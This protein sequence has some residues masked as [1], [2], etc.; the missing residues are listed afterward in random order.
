MSRIIDLTDTSEDTEILTSTSTSGGLLGGGEMLATDPLEAYLHKNETPKYALRNKKAGV[1]IEAPG[2]TEHVQPS[3]EYQAVVLIT[4]L[5][6]L[7]VVGKEGGDEMLEVPLVDVIEAKSTSEGFRKSALLVV[8]EA[9]ETWQFACT[10]DVS[11]AASEVD[12]MAYIWANAQR[13]LDEAEGQLTE[14][15]QRL[16]RREVARARDELGD[17]QN[18]IE[19]AVRRIAEVGPAAQRHVESRAR[20]LADWLID[21]ERMLSADEAAKAHRN[22]QRAWGEGDYEAAAAAYEDAIASYR[23]ADSKDGPTPADDTLQS[24][25]SGALQERELLRVAPLMDADTARREAIDTDDPERAASAWERALDGYR[26][27]LSL[28]WG[29]DRRDFAADREKIQEQTVAIADDAIE[30]HMRAGQQWI[31]SADTL[32]VDGHDAQAREVYNRAREQF[33]LAGQLAHEVLPETPGHI[34]DALALVDERLSGSVPD[35]APDDP[36]L[37]TVVITG[38]DVQDSADTAPQTDRAQQDAAQSAT[39]NNTGEQHGTALPGHDET[40]G[41][42]ASKGGAR[43]NG[44][45]ATNDTPE[46]A[47][48]EP[49][50]RT[51]SEPGAGTRSDP[52][53]SDEANHQSTAQSETA[54]GA[55]SGSTAGKP[56]TA[57]AGRHSDVTTETPTEVDGT[58]GR[59]DSSLLDQIKEQKRQQSSA[60]QEAEETEDDPQPAPVESDNEIATD[61]KRL[62]DDQFDSLVAELWDA[63]GWDTGV[64]SV[65][66]QSTFDIIAFREQPVEERLGIWTVHEPGNAVDASVVG[67]CIQARS[68]SRGADVA[69]IITTAPVTTA[70]QSRADQNGIDIVDTEELTNLLK[71]EDLVGM[72]EEFANSME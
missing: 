43:A 5:R 54:V 13:L 31:Q 67:D 72:L 28:E 10:E 66:A 34:E 4:D 49:V 60:V 24:R 35:E 9:D 52:V 33:E 40:G 30:D 50:G 48:T 23:T 17:A 18:K 71:F 25:L 12:E 7:F 44:T 21:V 57:D 63:Q 19:T 70:G 46:S 58:G 65:G 14:A 41:T 8:T 68:D 51:Q 69:T 39:T 20:T 29:E 56:S 37:E 3:D 53:T 11:D 45:G 16:T 26:D 55:R 38:S 47:S 15:D 42:T 1:E 32:A 22:A 61:L 2:G 6:L 27:V 59:Q 64:V 36:A 62:S